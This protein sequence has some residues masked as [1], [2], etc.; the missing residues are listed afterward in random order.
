MYVENYD[1]F[2]GEGEI[3][4]QFGLEI[5]D[6]ITSSRYRVEDSRYNI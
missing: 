2:E 3:M 4:S 6:E 5:K 1:G